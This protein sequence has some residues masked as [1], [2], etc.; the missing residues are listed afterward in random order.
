[1]IN[2]DA[3]VKGYHVCSSSVMTCKNFTL[4]KVGEKG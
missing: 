1:M 4:K 3:V 2:I